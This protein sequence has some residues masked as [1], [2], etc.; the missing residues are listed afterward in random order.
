[1]IQLTEEQAK[2][3]DTITAFLMDSNSIENC[4]VLQGTAGT[5]KSTII[6]QVYQQYQDQIRLLKLVDKN[7]S[8]LQWMFT[9]TTNKAVQA[10]RDTAD[11]SEVRTIQSFLSLVPNSY[12]LQTTNRTREH[13]NLIVVIDECSYVDYN[14]S[15][16]ID[17]YLKGCKIIFMGDP[18]Q[19]PPVGLNHSPVFYEGYPTVHLTKSVRQQ[20]SPSIA[21]FC[22]KLQNFITTGMNF[23]QLQLTDEIVHVDADTFNSVIHQ[24]NTATSKILVNKNTSV[25]KYN[26]MLFQAMN[27][28]SLFSRGDTVINNHYI[29]G[30]TTDEEVIITRNPIALVEYDV[31]GHQYLVTANSGSYEVFVPEK[32]SAIKKTFKKFIQ[33]GKYHHANKVKERWADL[34][35]NFACTIHK[36]QGS[37]FDEVFIDLNDF[38]SI[39]DLKEL[40]RLLYV[41]MSRAKY[42]VTL[43][44][45]I[46]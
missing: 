26:S 17:T 24:M 28:R 2:A 21:E 35:P 27:N 25:N 1:M 30:I 9:A 11:I 32:P 44:G 18:T 15:S 19:L 29:K 23:P 10:L 45:D 38:K 8:G 12:G 39:R 16:F 41:A 36:S 13:S 3:R 40:A 5:G 34:R 42:K 22:K 14:L 7:I 33:E 6:K 46:R 20:H 4:I 37:T 31:K 43:T